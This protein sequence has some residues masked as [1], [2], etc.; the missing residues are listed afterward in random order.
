MFLKI[1]Y[2]FLLK[3]FFFKFDPELVHNTMVSFGS[4][5]GKTPIGKKVA[6]SVFYFEHPVLSQTLLGIHFKNPV[7]L[8]AG[9]DKD[10]ELVDILPD[11]GFGFEEIG[12][13][14]AE[15]C[16]GNDRPRLWRAPQ[17]KSLVVHYGLKS[18]GAEVMAHKLENRRFDFPIGTSIAKT[19]CEATVPE[20]AGIEDYLKGFKAFRSVG[21]YYTIN[22]S[23]PNTFGGQPFT[24]PVKLDHLLA[25]IDKISTKKPIFIKFSPDLSRKHVDAIL[26]VCDKHRVDGLILSNLTKNRKNPAIRDRNLPTYGGMS[27]KVVEKLSNDLLGY[28]YKKTK[29]KYIIVG[30]GGIFS[31]QDAYKKIRLGASLVQLITGMIYEGPQL[32]GDI[33]RGLVKLLKKD[34]YT[35]LSQAIGADFK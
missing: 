30:V 3:P 9:F 1:G 33:N 22:I 19:N 16:E 5:L 20:Q 31:A 18:A 12:S 4:W 21:D 6:H 8:A 23:C 35:H 28:V 26:K 17:S 10:G 32:I 2:K 25:A 13:I 24:H 34:G 15:R 7:G 29:G 27:G 14:T 11:I